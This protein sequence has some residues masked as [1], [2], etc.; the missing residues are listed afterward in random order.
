M[1]LVEEE[2]APDIFTG[3]L[4]NPHLSVWDTKL[5]SES[6]AEGRRVFKHYQLSGSSLALD[7]TART[8]PVSF[9][10]LKQSLIQTQH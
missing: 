8:K 9:A 1:Y 7:A 4:L 3:V 5:W 6:T 2:L 10:C